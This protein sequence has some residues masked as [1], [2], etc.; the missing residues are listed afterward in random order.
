MFAHCCWSQDAEEAENILRDFG[1]SAAAA[2]SEL[3]PSLVASLASAAARSG[4]GAPGFE[5]RGTL[6]VP[7]DFTVRSAD[8]LDSARS[9]CITLTNEEKAKEMQQLQIMIRD[10]VKEVLHGVLLD[11]VLEDGCLLTCRCSMDNRLTTV[12]LQVREIVR[13]IRLVDIQEICSGKELQ[14]MN[15]TTPLDDLCVTFAMM[16]DQCVTF[17]FKT[18]AAREHFSTCM[19][20]LRLAC[21]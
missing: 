13:H 3:V 7:P 15:T 17:K 20:V 11:I 16:N 18:V 21:E 14:N 10:F 1:G 2:S 9:R 19:K 8:S 12:S 4:P 6:H 5:V